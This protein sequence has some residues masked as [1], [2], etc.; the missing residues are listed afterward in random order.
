MGNH[1]H[2]GG[3]RLLRQQQHLQPKGNRRGYHCADYHLRQKDPKRHA[4]RALRD[5]NFQVVAAGDSYN[6]TSMLAE[7]HAGILFR[8]PEN[9]VREFPAFRHVPERYEDLAAEI[10]AAFA[11]VPSAQ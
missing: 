5:L 4:V 1:A 11:A 7:A 3:Y 2:L 9:V 10:A 6:D 8:A